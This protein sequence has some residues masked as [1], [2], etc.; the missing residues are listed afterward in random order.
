MRQLTLKR[1]N[2]RLQACV[3]QKV[4]SA[5][6]DWYVDEAAQEPLLPVFMHVGG[7]PPG[8]WGLHPSHVAEMMP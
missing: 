1:L 2:K 6:S 5:P 8:V 7:P 4:K 3:I